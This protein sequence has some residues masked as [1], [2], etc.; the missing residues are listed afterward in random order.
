LPETHNRYL[1]HPVTDFWRRINIYWKIF[2]QKI[3]FPMV[4]ALK[5]LARQAITIRRWSCSCSPA[6][7]S[8]QWFWLRGVLFAW[9]DVVLGRPGIWSCELL[10]E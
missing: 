7:H 10:Y 2:M 8:Y 5:R 3:F 1:L 4:F 6:L 9:H